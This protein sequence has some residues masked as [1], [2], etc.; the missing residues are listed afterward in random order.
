M[1]SC[2]E[3]RV[4]QVSINKRLKKD[5]ENTWPDVHFI[6]HNTP[7]GIFEI[8]LSIKSDTLW[9]TGQNSEKIQNHHSEHK[10]GGEFRICN[11]ICMVYQLR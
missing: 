6:N 4:R 7:L 8:R 11:S 5:T 9:V 2:I 10:N 1:V 3:V